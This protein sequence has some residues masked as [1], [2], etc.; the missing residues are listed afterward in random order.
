[1][2]IEEFSIQAISKHQADALVTARHYSR[3]A[4]MFQHA[5]ALVKGCQIEGVVVYGM[6]PIMVQKHS[7]SDPNWPIFELTRLVIQTDAPN[8]ASFLVGNSLKML[9]SPSA[10]VSYADTEFNH[11]GIVYQ[12]TNWIYTGATVSHDHMYL[13]DGKR[14]HPRTLAARGIK[15][16]K[17]WA[18]ENNI[19]TVKPM[20]KHRYF[21]LN[22]NKRERRAM[23]SALRYSPISSYPKMDQKRY[24]DGDRVDIAV[25]AGL[26]G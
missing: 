2:L 16:P 21:F 8:A 22:G 6:P 24:D 7:F 5:F 3:R 23:L 26:F 15:S 12:S 17:L 9:P 19:E 18:K 13:I 14:V 25:D 11:C 1:M 10:V 4:S 20:Q